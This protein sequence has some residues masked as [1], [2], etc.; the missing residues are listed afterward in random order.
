MADQ[1]QMT[2]LQHLDELRWRLVRIA[3]AIILV[4]IVIWVFQEWIFR[5]V[6]Q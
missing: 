5:I 1:K 4:G 2:F 6:R 3:I